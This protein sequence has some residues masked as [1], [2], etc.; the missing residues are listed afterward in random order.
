[1]DDPAEDPLTIATRHVAMDKAHVARQ[2]AIVAKLVRDGHEEQAVL[3]RQVLET[4][5]TT[6]NLAR[7]HLD[8]ER[9]K[10]AT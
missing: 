3:A 8:R 2:E 10:R 5:R 6:L 1:M 9:E 4:M 7:E